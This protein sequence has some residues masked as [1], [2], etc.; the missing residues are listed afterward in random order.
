MAYPR[1]G[2]QC[3]NTSGLD[4]KWDTGDLR[5]T[6]SFWDGGVGRLYT[7]TARDG[8]VG[9]GATES[10]IRWWELDPRFSL[11]DSDVTRVGTI[12]A[13]ARDLAWPSISTDAD[14]KVWVNHAR[15]GAGECLAAY[16]AVIQRGARRAASVLIREGSGRYE[17]E[18][19]VERW[20]DYTAI[21]RDPLTPTQMATFGATPIDDGVGGPST[22]LWQQVIASVADA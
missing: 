18:P 2:R 8:N 12:G 19:G 11:G 3:G 13:P 6:T 21:S 20:G 10:V 15:A 9:G 7:A 4:S 1:W 22:E 5:L 17:F 16:A 14:G